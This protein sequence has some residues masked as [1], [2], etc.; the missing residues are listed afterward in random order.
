MSRISF[1]FH[2]AIPTGARNFLSV[3][4]VPSLSIQLPSTPTLCEAPQF[5]HYI[6]NPGRYGGLQHTKAQRGA[7]GLSLRPFFYLV[8]A[9]T[10]V[11]LSVT[12]ATS[13]TIITSQANCCSPVNYSRFS[14]YWAKGIHYLSAY[15]SLLQCTLS[16]LELKTYI[17]VLCLILDC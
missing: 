4:V 2:F 11:F 12:K 16:S 15:G 13:H 1:L 9:K 14:L 17:Q 5:W 10:A 8:F 7:A 3:K 6:C